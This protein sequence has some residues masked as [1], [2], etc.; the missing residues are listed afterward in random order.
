MSKKLSVQTIQNLIS[1]KTEE[2]LVITHVL[3][4]DGTYKILF[5]HKQKGG[6]LMIYRNERSGFH[7]VEFNYGKH[8][9]RSHFLPKQVETTGEILFILNG[10]VELFE[11]Y[12][13][14]AYR[15]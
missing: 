3:I 5:N 13:D 14:K 1:K 8:K 12:Y 15:N 7:E 11:N 4:L 9:D 10:F 6:N 2:G